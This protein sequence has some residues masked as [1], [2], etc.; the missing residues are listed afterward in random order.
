MNRSST[1]PGDLA[2]GESDG[3]EDPHRIRSEAELE[4]V[5]GPASPIAEAK[6][7]DR[8]DP[9]AR[10]FLAASPLALVATVAADGGVD[11]SP[12]G[13]APG[14]VV[15]EDERTLLLPER[16]GNRLAL[17]FRNLL[18]TG[19]IGLIFLLPGVRETLRIN[20]RATITRDPA[21]CERLAVG[22]RPALLVT[23]VTIEECFL[24]CGKALIRSRL[25]QPEAW[26]PAPSISFGR[27]MAAKN[28]DGAPAPEQID[29]A[30]EQN[31]V[32]GLY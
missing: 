17:G 23:R 16:P 30:I 3:P 18:D 6:I 29:A 10:E 5:L 2:P 20:G 9:V 13:D 12:K 19:R 32:D 25:W 22:N 24:H 7:A 11:V 4:S 14:F 15:A 26:A 1:D 27:Q 31:Y 21:L 8:L 28:V